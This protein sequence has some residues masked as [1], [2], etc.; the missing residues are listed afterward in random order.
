[1]RRNDHKEFE[2]TDDD[3]FAIEIAKQAAHRFIK[4]PQIS[5]QQVASLR[6]AL[7]ALERLPRITPDSFYQFGICYRWGSEEFNEMRY[8][9]FLISENC[10]EI[11][12][13]GSVYDAS[14]GGDSFSEPGWLI[15]V[16][17]YRETGCDLVSLEDMI[18]EYL[19]LGAEITVDDQT[20]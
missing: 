17:G 10:F 18:E 8:V 15:E 4:H 20:E 2:L 13:G 11:S 19:N 1:L 14:V 5:P 9:K 7:K 6:G 16:G 12:V 3:W